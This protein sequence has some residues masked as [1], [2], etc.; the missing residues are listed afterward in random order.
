M[1][2][3]KKI[4][5]GFFISDDGYGHVVRQSSIINELLKK[6]SKNLE[7]HIFGNKILA[8]IKSTFSDK[9]IYNNFD[10]IIKTAKEENGSLS[11]TKT[12]KIFTSWEKKKNS[13]I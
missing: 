8:K 2:R 3:Q 6:N 12:Y 13:L 5:I 4:K 11:L 1:F 7:I 10:T 9:V